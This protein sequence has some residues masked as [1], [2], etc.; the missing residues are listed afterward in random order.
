M[1]AEIEVQCQSYF[2]PEQSQ[3]HE[4]RFVFGYTITI[5]NHSAAPVKLL[6]RSWLITDA[7]GKVTTVQGDGVIGQQPV[8]APQKSF[9]YS[10]GALLK[11]PVGT[12]QG[13]Y[14]MVSN[15]QPITVEIPVF[16]LALP[17]VV[18]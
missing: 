11:T 15:E 8:I 12:M 7:D 16:R 6:T 4:H 2:I 18:H 14:Q 10:S 3:V 5:T 13:Q 9:T 1:N 17:N